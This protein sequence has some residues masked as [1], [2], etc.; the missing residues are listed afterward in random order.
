MDDRGIGSVGVCERAV[1]EDSGS[2]PPKRPSRL[3]MAIMIVVFDVGGPL[4]AY[5][6]LRH[7]GHLPTVGALILSGLLPAIGVLLNAIQYR[8]LDIFGLMILGGIAFGSLLGLVT[9]DAKLYLLEGSLPSVAFS[10]LCLASLKTRQP[11]LYRL[12]LEVIGP[13]S[14]KGKQ[15]T[16]AWAYERFRAAFKLITVV[17]AIGYLIEAALRAVVAMTASTG[18]A[19]VC[20]KVA[21]Y[22]FAGVLAAWT[23]AYGERKLRG[24]LASKVTSLRS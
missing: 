9:H 15:V 24:V 18:M 4:A 20:S 23:L 16:A 13:D 3:R 22:V 7:L 19:L 12:T 5:S 17:W 10:I 11:L 14:K 6:L 2:T 1:T 21:P 8:R